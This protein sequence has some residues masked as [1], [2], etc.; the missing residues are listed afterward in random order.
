MVDNMDDIETTE[1][2]S[3][4]SSVDLKSM[5]DALEANMNST[6]TGEE[7]DADVEEEIAAPESV[8]QSNQVNQEQQAVAVQEERPALLPPADMRKEEKDAFLNPTAE[9]AH[10][11]QG[12][13]NRRAYETRSDY[14]RKMQEVEELRKQNAVL[15]DN[16][17]QYEADYAKKG[18]NIA[19]VAKRSIAWDQAMEKNPIA[20]AKEWL[21]SYGLTPEDLAK[22]QTEPNAPQYQ[23]YL[24]K[25][26][27]ERIAEERV[28]SLLQQQ[29]QKAVEYYNQKVVESFINSKPVF[30]DPETASQIEAEMAPIVQALTNTGR[31]NDAGAVLE[32]AYNYVINGNPAY[33]SLVQKMTA[34]PAI[35]EQKAAVEKAKAAAKSISGSAGSGTPRVQTK[36]LRDNLRRRLVGGD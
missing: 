8:D 10:I 17:K 9:N 16:I 21:E 24:T 34:K 18:I 35:K 2:E 32:T 4:T 20:A 1:T 30:R 19:D 14:S 6:E 25:E 28:Q 3:N 31:Y 13:L 15:Y 27:A 33:S 12:Y 36:D 22:A 11:L 7:V 23:N 29:E 5:R 26:D